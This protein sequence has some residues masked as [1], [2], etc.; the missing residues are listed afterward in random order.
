MGRDQQWNLKFENSQANIIKDYFQYQTHMLA[1]LSNAVLNG[2]IDAASAIT[3]LNQQSLKSFIHY[4]ETQNKLLALLNN[5][6]NVSDITLDDLSGMPIKRYEVEVT[7]LALN[8]LAGYQYPLKGSV[9]LVGGECAGLEDWIEKKN[10]KPYRVPENAN[11]ETIQAF[12]QETVC[13]IIG[14]SEKN[15]SEKEGLEYIKQMFLAAKYLSVTGF[16]SQDKPFFVA[17]TRLGGCFGINSNASEFL[18]GSIS[19]LCKTAARE[20]KSNAIVRC[21]DISAEA[22]DDSLISYIDEELKYGNSV[23]VGRVIDGRRKVLM[24]KEYYDNK[25]SIAQPQADDV[26]IVSGGARGITALCVIDLAKLYHCRFLLLG[27]SRLNDEP[28]EFAGATDIA[29]IQEILI[30][31]HNTGIK[32]LKPIEINYMAKEIMAQREIR[33]TLEEINAAGGTALY[34][35]CDVRNVSDLEEVVNKGTASLGT[36]TGMI[37]GAGIISDNLLGKKTESDFENVFGIKYYGLTNMLSMVNTDKIKYLIMFSSI[38]G[39]FGNAGQADYSCGNE[40]LNHFARY[41]KHTHPECLTASVNWGAWDAGMV[42]PIIKNEMIKRGHYLIDPDLG[43][44]Y[45]RALFTQ[46]HLEGFNQVVINDND[47]LEVEL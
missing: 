29:M 8:Q 12:F 43:K 46:E 9:L 16:C 47:E 26:F 2:N 30:Q 34:F 23:E 37:H 39:F 40:Y 11:E 36:I 21:I 6:V 35:S 1:E 33:S 5:R 17:I 3:N 27:R 32:K 14:I 20:W 24:L 22:S 38:A 13:G 7:D 4:N 10:L 28:P 25:P 15:C 19:G 44:R 42:Q 45:F 18:T 41:W 31:K